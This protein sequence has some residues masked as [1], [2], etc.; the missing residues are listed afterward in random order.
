MS[1]S[2]LIINRFVVIKGSEFIYDE[3]F[4][5][6]INIICGDNTT[7][8]STII[9]LLNYSLGSE[10]TDWTVEQIGCDFVIVEVCIND[11]LYCLKREVVKSG[12]ASM[13][14]FEGR[15]QEG[16]ENPLSWLK[17]PCR[18]SA[19]T[20]SFSQQLFEVLRLPRHKTDDDKNLTMHQILRLIYVDQLSATTKLLK[21]DLKYDNVTLRR[22]IGEYLLGIDD[23]E[24]HNLRQDS[25]VANKVFEKLNGELNAIY[26]FF[27]NDASLISEQSLINEIKEL[28]RQLEE[29][30]KERQ[31]IREHQKDEL[32]EKLKQKTLSLQKKINEL[33]IKKQNFEIEKSELNIELIDTKLF[34]ESLDLRKKAL[35]NSRLTNSALGSIS[36]AYC[37]SCLSPIE[38]NDD[39]EAC[40]LCKTKTKANGR[41]LAFI[42]ML[43]ELN[44]QISESSEL[45]TIFQKRV[46]EINSEL[47]NIL[48]NLSVSK[49]EYQ[50][51]LDSTSS[52]DA[53]TSQISVDIGFCKSQ[54]L[55]LEEKRS[56][57]DRVAALQI[58]KQ[59]AQTRINEIEDKLSVIK[60]IQKQRYEYV[61]SSI[62]SITMRLLKQ[63]S[64]QEPSFLVPEEVS[65][66]FARDKMQVNGRSKFSASSM[67]VMKNC[68][69][70]SIFLHAVDDCYA[71]LPNLLI[72]DNIEDKGMTPERSQ[73]FQHL[74]VKE[75][76][77][78]ESEY[79]VIFTTTMI[80]PDLNN[81]PLCIGPY[82]KTGSYTLNVK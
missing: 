41:D 64:G 80:A 15:L 22:A 28:G 4:H 30:H 52:A 27:G 24:A 25:L 55:T 17:Y 65:F 16:L 61:Y 2:T 18:R 13:F 37:P 74:I 73:N 44:F 66:D 51:I 6:G 14:I 60:E 1:S 20:H 49:N 32:T 71:R 7:G 59:K 48:R 5:R 29:L 56:L 31:N 38:N 69:R 58:A 11:A 57:V 9:E 39:H 82:Y 10:V 42:Q 40:S 45:V 12:Q 76:E 63:D 26:K 68:I 75:C 23:L 79:Q 8:K 77:K 70:L 62:E 67:T 3:E 53:L 46:D 50:E 72:M 54:I 34:L 43:N 21:E 19:N 81:S 35:D 33:N 78:L 36:F 47:P